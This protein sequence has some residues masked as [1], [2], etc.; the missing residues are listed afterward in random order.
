MGKE[1]RP[2]P[3][4]KMKTSRAQASSSTRMRGTQQHLRTALQDLPAGAQLGVE[5]KPSRCTN[6]P[7]FQD[8]GPPPHNHDLSTSPSSRSSCGAFDLS[9]VYPAAHKLQ[10]LEMERLLAAARRVRA[11]YEE[12]R[13]SEEVMTRFLQD[14][15]RH[16]R[17]LVY[18]ELGGLS[19]RQELLLRE[20]LQ[21]GDVKKPIGTI[22]PTTTTAPT[23]VAAAPEAIAPTGATGS[24]EESK[25]IDP[26]LTAWIEELQNT[27]D[28]DNG[29]NQHGKTCAKTC[30][31]MRTI[32][33]SETT[34]AGGNWAAS[35]GGLP[36]K[37][38]E[39]DAI[40]LVA[41]GD[42]DKIYEYYV[43]DSDDEDGERQWP[44]LRI[45]IATATP[46]AHS[47]QERFAQTTVDPSPKSIWKTSEPTPRPQAQ[48]DVGQDDED[49]DSDAED[50]MVLRRLE[51][52]QSSSSITF[53]DV[54]D[55]RRQVRH[56]RRP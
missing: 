10:K 55:A 30:P 15:T 27:Y 5:P 34:Q 42:I 13:I 20:E 21:C 50:T 31:T 19:W 53:Q 45:D 16:L 28:V 9:R 47:S 29:K 17:R 33:A 37:L 46:A 51:R 6:Q 48:V 52:L 18:F 12:K 1:S 56:D 54:F 38:Y 25:E 44:L 49:D 23:T 14:P 7:L 41:N 26:L 22:E 8:L 32:L 36:P 40:R 39:E 3:R 11:R 43:L 2:R 4:L 24:D 35:Y